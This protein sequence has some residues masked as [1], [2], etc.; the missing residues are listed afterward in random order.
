MQI[1]SVGPDAA[2]SESSF[3][4]I[5]R[6]QE[7]EWIVYWYL[8]GRYEGQGESVALGKDGLLLYS[9]L[10]HC[11]CFDPLE[12]WEYSGSKLTVAE[13]LKDKTSIHDFD[14]RKEVEDKVRALLLP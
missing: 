2:F 13:F 11:S 12:D 10:G 1:F 9:N 4:E 8:D 5:L 6:E 14:F 3:K 7:Y